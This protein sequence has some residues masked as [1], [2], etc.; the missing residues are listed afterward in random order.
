MLLQ[1]VCSRLR[2]TTTFELW[3]LWG[4]TLETELG[5]PQHQHEPHGQKKVPSRAGKT[6]IKSARSDNGEPGGSHNLCSRANKMLGFSKRYAVVYVK[7]SYLKL[8]PCLDVPWAALGLETAMP[9]AA[10]RQAWP[11]LAIHTTG[12]SCG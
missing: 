6:L 9:E 12:V 7:P 4:A 8:G 5:P 2:R 3:P 1:K 10:P 11:G